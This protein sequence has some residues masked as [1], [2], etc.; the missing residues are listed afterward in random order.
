MMPW[1]WPSSSR[2]LL[3]STSSSGAR[4]K[5]HFPS[6]LRGLARW[7]QLCPQP[8]ASREGFLRQARSGEGGYKEGVPLGELFRIQVVTQSR[9]TKFMSWVETRIFSLSSDKREGKKNQ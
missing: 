6:G 5:C 2:C 9:V 8:S 1:A 7:T 4:R 3:G